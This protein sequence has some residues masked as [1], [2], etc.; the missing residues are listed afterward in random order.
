MTDLA[1]F[2][3]FSYL[4]SIL[5]IAALWDMRFHEIPNWLTL[6][7]VIM[8]VFYHSVSGGA[9]GFLYSLLGVGVGMA[10]FIIPY[11]TR[12]M[13]A[14]DL[15]LMGTI[16]GFVGVRGVLLASLWTALAGGLYAVILLV[17]YG[18]INKRT[19]PCLSTTCSYTLDKTT[20]ITSEVKGK[21]PR[22]YYGI[23]IAVGTLLSMAVKIP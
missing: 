17:Y 18:C 9:S 23:A 8:A 15:K 19:R 6:P 7:S 1:G 13:A 14:G 5:V 10:I 4:I 21:K 16:G 2:L 11:L 22:L 3:L 20:P 12:G